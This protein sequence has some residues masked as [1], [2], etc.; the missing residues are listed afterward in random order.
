MK[1]I[2]F[3]EKEKQ[4]I[5]EIEKN[6]EDFG[7]ISNEILAEIVEE[8]LKNDFDGQYIALGNGYIEHDTNLEENILKTEFISKISKY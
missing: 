3:T 4:I 7:N 5:D 8:L 6:I 1:T 2:Y